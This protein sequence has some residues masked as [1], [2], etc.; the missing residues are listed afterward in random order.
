MKIWGNALT[1]LMSLTTILMGWF[2]LSAPLEAD[3][4]YTSA[5]TTSPTPDP[6]LIPNVCYGHYP[7]RI[8]KTGQVESNKNSA[9]GEIL[10][11]FE[12]ED[13]CT[14]R[15]H[16]IEYPEG[17]GGQSYTCPKKISFQTKKITVKTD[18]NYT[19]RVI[20]K[21]CEGNATTERY[22]IAYDGKEFEIK[23]Y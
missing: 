8:K 4:S 21:D 20:V 1:I 17:G 10:L 9:A 2:F 3:N 12:A 11:M 14:I 16:F 23:R 22:Q 15:D 7:P 13:D 18:K 19:I 6:S 5:P